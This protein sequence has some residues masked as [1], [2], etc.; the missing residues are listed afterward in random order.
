[1]L[2]LILIDV[3]HSQKVVFSFEKGSNRLN[4]SSSGSLY[5]VKKSPLPPLKF[6]SP[7]PSTHAAIWKTLPLGNWVVNKE[8]KIIEM[9]LRSC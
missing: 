4:H 6:L 9:L 5:L 7:S 1:M 2:I 8:S 3:Q